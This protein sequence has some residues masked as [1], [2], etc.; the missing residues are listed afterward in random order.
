MKPPWDWAFSALA[1]A[2]G[3]LPALLIA[4]AMFME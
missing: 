3:A 4:A 2:F 1:I